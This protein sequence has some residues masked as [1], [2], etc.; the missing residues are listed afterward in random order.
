M[1]K[2]D[3]PS[4]CKVLLGSTNASGATYNALASEPCTYVNIN[5]ESSTTLQ[6]RRLGDTNTVLVPPLA[7]HKVFGITNA[8]QIEY[9]RADVSN[10]V[11]TFSAEA[12]N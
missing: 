4:A 6:I 5:N 7:E 9:R 10:T 11:V 1:N 8:N 2:N 3:F 12:Y